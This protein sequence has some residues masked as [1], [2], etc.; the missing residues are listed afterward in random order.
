MTWDEE[1]T[2]MPMKLTREN[3]RGTAKSCGR[4]AAAGRDARDAKS[5]AF[6]DNE[7]AMRPGEEET[8]R[9]GTD[10]TR[11]AI[12]LMQD[13][14]L[15]TIA[16]PSSLPCTVA[17]WRMIG[18]TPFALM[19]HQMKNVIPAVGAT[20]ALRVKRWRI[21]WI[22]NHIA[23]SEMSQKRKKQRKSRVVVPDDSGR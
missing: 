22:G 16:Q 18:P 20:M 3:V 14:R 21:L 4:P 19:M 6:L 5:G 15:E 9:S 11:V 12:L 17:G 10:V 8:K 7:H 1:E 13:M 2:I 23:G